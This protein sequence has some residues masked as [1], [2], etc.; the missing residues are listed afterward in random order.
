MT[1]IGKRAAPRGVCRIFKRVKQR[2]RRLLVG[3]ESPATPSNCGEF[4]KLS[5][6]K[7]ALK[8][9][10]GRGNDLGYSNNAPDDTMDNPQPSPTS[11]D[12][13]AV[14]RLDG[15]GFRA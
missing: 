11:S 10:C 1:Q 4:L 8:G 15:D 9:A 5:A 7:Q 2:K 6:T 12:T 13:D 3:C 14:Q